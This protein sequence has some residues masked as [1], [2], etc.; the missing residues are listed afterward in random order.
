MVKSK[1]DGYTLVTTGATVSMPELYSFFRKAPYTSGDAVP[2]AQWSVFIPVIAVRKDAP[3]NTLKEFLEEAKGKGFKF[4]GPGRTASNYILGLALAKKNNVKLGGIPFEGDAKSIPALLGGH[5]DMAILMVGSV[6][7]LISSG[8]LK[9]LAVAHPERIID[10]PN[11]PTITEQGY[12]VGFGSMPLGTW[13]PAKTP[14]DRINTL[15]EGI[16]KISQDKSF[17]AMMEKLGMP[18]SYADHEA[19]RKRLEN[20]QRVLT[21]IFRELEYLPK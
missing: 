5:I 17:L 15:S 10:F 2:V 12:D 14:P 8:A 20:T 3:W 11:T 1:P 7:P 9:L 18:V 16:R 6:K 13:A 21:E 19:F 4:G